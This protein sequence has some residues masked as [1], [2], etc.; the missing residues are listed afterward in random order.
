MQSALD[1]A[2]GHKVNKQIKD[3]G[4]TATSL[5]R[6]PLG[7]VALFIVLVYGFASLVTIF[8]GSL[9]PSE[10]TPLIYFLTFFPILV[11]AT[12]S[13]LVSRHSENL[14]SPSDYKDE[15][16]YLR[17]RLAIA[18]SLS[19]AAMSKGTAGPTISIADMESFP[20]R[21]ELLKLEGQSVLWVDDNP[22]NNLFVR[23]AFETAGLRVLSTLSTD[24]ALTALARQKFAAIIS[25]MGRREGPREGYVLLDRLR[26]SGNHIP[27]FIYAGSSKPE[28]RAE[29]LQRGAQGS[30]N[31][32]K[33]LFEMVTRAALSS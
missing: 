31:S 19:A 22:D 17:M 21:S 24:E 26:Q 32:G 5:A 33:E 30:T 28:H 1:L 23:R 16:N 12:F 11:L 27:F 15:Q 20:T 7:I 2:W 3:F 4:T 13:W 6:N 10:R 29:A 14:Y 18:T 8:A 25:D 9:T